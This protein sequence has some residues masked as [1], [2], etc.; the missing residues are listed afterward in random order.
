MSINS[1]VFD[2]FNHVVKNTQSNVNMHAG[3]TVTL[4]QMHTE[5]LAKFKWAE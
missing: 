4:N 1:F 2:E 3:K 5:A